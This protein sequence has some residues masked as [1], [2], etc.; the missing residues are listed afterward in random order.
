MACNLLTK[1]A[2]R[3]LTPPRPPTFNR[4]HMYKI[5]SLVCTQVL[6]NEAG[7]TSSNG[8]L[9]HATECIGHANIST[10]VRYKDETLHD[11]IPIHVPAF[12]A[13]IA[14][15]DIS[16]A[17]LA[18]TI[19]FG[20]VHLS[21]PRIGCGRVSVWTRNFAQTTSGS[22]PFSEPQ[23]TCIWWH[24][25]IYNEVTFALIP[26]FIL[27]PRHVGPSLLLLLR[28]SRCLDTQE[29]GLAGVY[30]FSLLL[31]LYRDHHKERE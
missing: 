1:R 11:N 9:F 23:I 20:L 12:L 19:P 24:T 7:R 16:V 10:W 29:L 25:H 28:S 21:G 13:L 18:M 14:S 27:E 31:H 26:N 17:S 5:S 3:P 22:S 6:T 30:V 15:W 4:S 8:S 2:S